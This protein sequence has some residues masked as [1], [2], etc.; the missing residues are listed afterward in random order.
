ML[1]EKF[2]LNYTPSISDCSSKEFK[3]L[4]DYN[5]IVKLRNRFIFS[6]TELMRLVH[7]KKE[8]IQISI[9]TADVIEGKSKGDREI[10]S[11]YLKDRSSAFCCNRLI[12]LISKTCIY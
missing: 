12:N 4:L 7:F 8:A 9:F 2:S 5:K 3:G 10:K 6:S 11:F 1:D